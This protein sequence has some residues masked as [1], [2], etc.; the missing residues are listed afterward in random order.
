[1]SS[2]CCLQTCNPLSR[3]HQ[4][5]TF[6]YNALLLWNILVFNHHRVSLSNTHYFTQVSLQRGAR[7]GINTIKEIMTCTSNGHASHII[8]N[9]LLQI[10]AE[11]LMSEK[12][13]PI[14]TQHSLIMKYTE[15]L[16]PSQ[17]TIFTKDEIDCFGYQAHLEKFLHF[18]LRGEGVWW[19]FDDVSKSLYFMMGLKSPNQDHK[20]PQF[21]IFEAGYLRQKEII[22]K[23]LGN[24]AFLL[25]IFHCQ[26]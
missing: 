2:Q 22:L 18:L 16:S 3:D 1:M 12:P 15:T 8:P 21:T 17:N 19:H 25:K 24:T 5:P 6:I 7:T 9:S 13:K 11:N 4:N 20:V 10:Q 23:K 14:V 26:H